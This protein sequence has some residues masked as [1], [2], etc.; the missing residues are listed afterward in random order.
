MDLSG[1]YEIQNANTN[2]KKR[3]NL[4]S[5]VCVTC[6]ITVRTGIAIRY[7]CSKVYTMIEIYKVLT[8]TRAHTRK[9]FPARETIRKL[10]TNKNKG[11]NEMFTHKRNSINTRR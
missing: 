8:V 5:S 6:V 10:L 2:K 1:K 9:T 3:T 7:E 11:C 4:K